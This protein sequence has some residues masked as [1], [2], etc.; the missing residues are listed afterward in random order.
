MERNL[1]K[2][3]SRKERKGPPELLKSNLPSAAKKQI[4]QSNFMDGER[5]NDKETQQFKLFQPF[6]QFP[7]KPFFEE[8][9]FYRNKFE[10]D[11]Q[12]L[13][14]IPNV[15]LIIDLLGLVLQ[16]SLMSFDLD[17]FTNF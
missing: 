4:K 17:E 13:N 14:N 16:N 11:F 15:H 8:D 5:F 1:E 3:K 12:N 9:A 10:Q 6:Q 2:V 7:E